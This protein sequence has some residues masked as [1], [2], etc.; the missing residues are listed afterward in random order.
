ME[1]KKVTPAQVEQLYTFTRAHFVAYYDLQTEL[2]DHIANAIEAQ[3]QQNPNLS[4][5]HALALEF[6]KFGVYGFS[7][8]VE[9][10]Q[11]ALA[12]KYRKLMGLYFKQFFTFPRIV[13]TALLTLLT[14]KILEYESLL[15]IVLIVLLAGTVLIQTARH[16]GVYGKKVK[17][18]GKRWLLEEIIFNCG[19]IAAYVGLFFQLFN[20]VIKD[21]VSTLTLWLLSV[22]YVVAALASYVVVFVIPAKAEEHLKTT[23]PEYNL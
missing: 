13:L 19:G 10:R 20:F 2:A 8:V 3:W 14:F 15:Y 1:H 9:Q 18:T 21:N 22:S 16:R 5:D 6:K 17:V 11:K 4:F 23:Y 7:D 12:K